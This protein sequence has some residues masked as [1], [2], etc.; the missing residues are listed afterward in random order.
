MGDKGARM[1]EESKF[2]ASE[3]LSKLDGLDGITAKAMFGGHGIFHNMQMFAIVDSKGRIFLKITSEN[4]DELER[5]ST[6]KHSRMPYIRIP[7]A[8]LADHDLL[9]SL[10]QKAFN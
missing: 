9:I 8:V 7:E 10:A 3:L 6:E 1:N 2:A 4:K 5:L